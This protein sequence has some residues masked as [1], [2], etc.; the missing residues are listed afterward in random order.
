MADTDDADLRR[1]MAAIATADAADL[2]RKL[3]VKRTVMQGVRALTPSNATVFGRVRTLRMLPEREDL[4]APV[5]GPVNR[6]LYD[7]LE[8]GEVL[9]VDASANPS[10]AVLGDM[11]LARLAARGAAAVIVDGA[12]R[13]LASVAGMN[14]PIFAREV[15]PEVFMTHLRP[16]DRDIAVQCGGVLVQPTDYVLADADGVVVVPAT[17]V[18][19]LADLAESKREDDAFSRALLNSGFPL[20]S[21]YPLPAHMRKFLARYRDEGKLPSFEETNIRST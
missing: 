10:V 3:G 15:S 18:N 5:N 9:I 2:L 4:T 20:D 8:A 14:L 13:D 16:W 19:S 21:S 12:V 17:V 6:G 1:R 11:M 7:T